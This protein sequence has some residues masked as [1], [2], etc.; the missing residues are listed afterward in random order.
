MTRGP[1]LKLLA[2]IVLS[3]GCLL[4][5]PLAWA[6]Y[7]PLGSGATKLSFDKSFLSLL[8]QNGVKLSA[9]APA[10]LKGGAVSFPVSGGKFDP[11]AAKGTVD[12]EGALVFRAGG[13]SIPLKALQLKTTQ[14]R[15]P[16]SAK[17]G[18]SQL[19]LASAGS[20]AVSRAGFGDKVKASTLSLSSK[21]ATRLG[22]KL[23]LRG[24]F[25]EGQPMGRT[26]TNAQPETITVLGQG[27]A[28]FVFAPGISA[29]LSSL[30][31]AVNPIFPA[32]HIGAA[33]TLPIFGGAISADAAI[34]TLETSGA[35]ELLQ[36]GGGQVFWAEESLDFAAKVAAPEVTIQ[37]SPPYAG[38][39]GRIPVADL[40]LAA[41][42]VSDPKARTITVANA[43]LTLQ[44]QSAATFNEVFAKPQGKSGVFVPG[45]ALGTISFVAQ[46]Q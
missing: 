44:A 25:K 15:S 27:K 11:T 41:A 2:G 42:A 18:G 3:L 21:L 6:D 5:A 28:S 36:L 37:P 4:A 46:G 35:L 19:K 9:V 20:L 26:V 33:F 10:K 22:K 14:R 40:A 34:G 12:H 8:Q 7:D 24:V 16:L 30:F 43:A 29:K 38:K 39:L 13:R 23:R 31:V 45:E 17:V 32:E 1:R